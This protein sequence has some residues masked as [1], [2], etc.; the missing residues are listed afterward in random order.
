MDT[1]GER[2]GLGEVTISLT[3]TDQS[4]HKIT[5]VLVVHYC[6]TKWWLRSE[7]SECY[8]VRNQTMTSLPPSSTTSTVGGG[9]SDLAAGDNSAYIIHVYYH[10]QLLKLMEKWLLLCP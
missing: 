6:M 1:C 3:Q 7:S 9:V 4:D 8:E 10:L 2:D 5:S